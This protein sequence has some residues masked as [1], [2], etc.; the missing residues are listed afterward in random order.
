LST[1]KMPD[2]VDRLRLAPVMNAYAAIAIS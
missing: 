2:S 1:E